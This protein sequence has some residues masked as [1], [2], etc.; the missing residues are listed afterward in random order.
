MSSPW[1]DPPRA[2]CVIS[3]AKPAERLCPDIYTLNYITKTLSFRESRAGRES[4]P[5]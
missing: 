1:C 4:N 5:V 3:V 2:E